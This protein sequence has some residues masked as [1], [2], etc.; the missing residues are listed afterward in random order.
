MSP[1]VYHAQ[2]SPLP[3]LSPTVLDKEVLKNT[4]HGKEMNI[5]GDKGSPAEGLAMVRKTKSNTHST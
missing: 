2:N 5:Y 1:L 4:Q 3:P